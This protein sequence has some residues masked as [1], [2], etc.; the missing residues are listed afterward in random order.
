MSFIYVLGLENNKY[1]I[2]R[3]QNLQQRLNDHKNGLGS[4]WT[5]K[6]PFIKLI[7]Y[8]IGTKYEETAKTLEYMD[9]YGIENVRGGIYSNIDLTFE[10]CLTIQKEIYGANNKCL[11]CGIDGHYIMDCKTIICYRCGRNNHNAMDC[12]ETTHLNNGILNGCYRCG[13]PYHWKFR[14]NRSKDIY[15]RPINQRAGIINWFF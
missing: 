5:K 6:Y 15:G 1:Y 10:Q 7:D 9:R 8:R 14:C 13:R 4:Y 2:G 11:A 3:T 12:Q